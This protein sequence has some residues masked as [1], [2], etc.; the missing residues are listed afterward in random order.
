M[1]S[2]FDLVYHSVDL[3]HYFLDFLEHEN[4]ILIVCRFHMTIYIP[5]GFLFTL[6]EAHCSV[7]S[8]EFILRKRKYI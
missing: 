7:M 1:Q 6:P 2:S 5:A 8:N 3:R 4:T